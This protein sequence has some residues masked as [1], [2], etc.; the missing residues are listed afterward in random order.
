MFKWWLLV[1]IHYEDRLFILGDGRV[2][3]A[4]WPMQKTE[5]VLFNFH[6]LGGA[7]TEHTF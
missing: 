6:E 5:Q 4:A 2:K 7:T 1:Q 3:K